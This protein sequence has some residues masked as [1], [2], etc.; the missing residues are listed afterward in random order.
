MVF[1]LTVNKLLTLFR[2]ALFSFR[3]LREY[4][5]SLSVHSRGVGRHAEIQ[6][7]AAAGHL[8]RTR[9][10]RGSPSAV[11]FR[12]DLGFDVHAADGATLVGAEPLVHALDVE[13]M[14]ARESA[15]VLTFLELAEADGALLSVVLQAAVRSVLL[16]T[17][18]LLVGM[19]EGVPLDASL[20]GTAR[21]LDHP[22]LLNQP[23]VLLQPGG[24]AQ[25]GVVVGRAHEGRGG[26]VVMRAACAQWDER[27][28]MQTVVCR[29]PAV[30]MD[31]H[32]LLR[33]AGR[34]RMMVMYLRG[35]AWH[36]RRRDT[37]HRDGPRWPGRGHGR[38]S[39]DGGQPRPD[40]DM[41]AAW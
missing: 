40:A 18:E 13:E 34:R 31:I 16:G 30:A 25:E 32:R 22:T 8:G 10:A 6:E 33:I 17:E 39:R 5:C 37:L 28:R 7:A 15:D 20:R 35:D 29:R 14:E 26:V 4:G 3:T 27:R 12:L 21:E 1:K 36:G 23:H 41:Q 2:G 19:G 24:R 38:G 9:P 11:L